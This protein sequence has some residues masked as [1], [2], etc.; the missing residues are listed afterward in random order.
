MHSKNKQWHRSHA[1]GHRSCSRPGAALRKS[2]AS[3]RAPLCWAPQHGPCA[4]HCCNA[5]PLPAPAFGTE[6]DSGT[7][8]CC[9]RLQVERSDSAEAAAV[10]LADLASRLKAER[11]STSMAEAT[12]DLHNVVS[13][14]GKVSRIS[15]LFEQ[16]EIVCSSLC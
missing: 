10:I 14:L 8:Q 13:K 1:K 4:C 11:R 3:Q 7:G 2:P 15:S 16:V 12:K 9:Q 5:L 6:I